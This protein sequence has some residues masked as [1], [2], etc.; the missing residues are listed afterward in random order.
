M[1]NR[2]NTQRPMPVQYQDLE[3]GGELIE[4]TKE[5]LQA[6]GI[7]LGHAF[8]GEPGAPTRSLEVIDPRGFQTEILR[9]H[10]QAGGFVARITFSGWPLCPTPEWEPFAD[11]VELRRNVTA[12]EYAG[13]AEALRVAGLFDH[14]DVRRTVGNVWVASVSVSDKEA[15]SR[16]ASLKKEMDTWRAACRAMRRPAR[17]RPVHGA[18][19]G[20]SADVSRDATCAAEALFARLRLAGTD[21]AGRA[22]P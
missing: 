18:E 1:T 16:L 4:G 5:Q 14:R 6:F 22:V 20:E 7:G 10:R 17:L 19:L 15:E 11:G 8:P 21:G 3:W 2:S 12:D 9:N 13:S